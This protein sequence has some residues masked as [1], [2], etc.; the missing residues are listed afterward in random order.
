MEGPSPTTSCC[1]Q[2][3][4]AGGDSARVMFLIYRITLSIECSASTSLDGTWYHS[5][6]LKMVLVRETEVTGKESN[7]SWWP[8]VGVSHSHVQWSDS[9]RHVRV[10]ALVHMRTRIHL[11]SYTRVCYTTPSHL[12]KCI[13]FHSELWPKQVSK[14]WLPLRSPSLLLLGGRGR[15]ASGRPPAPELT[16]QRSFTLICL[17]LYASTKMFFKQRLQ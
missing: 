6:R 7:L 5:G 3:L 17:T 12:I 11:H 8:V 15:G 2:S 4:R 13:F 9:F 10:L 16:L 1:T 14:Q